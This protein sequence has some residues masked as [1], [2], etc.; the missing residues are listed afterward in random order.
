[1]IIRE[2]K[3]DRARYFLRPEKKLAVKVVDRE[4]FPITYDELESELKKKI[5]DIRKEWLVTDKLCDIKTQ[6]L[7][8]WF[9]ID[10]SWECQRLIDKI[11]KPF[12]SEPDG[13]V[14]KAKQFPI[15]DLIQFRNGFAPC[16]WHND[17]S[18]SMKLY[19]ATNTVYCFG[20]HHSGDPIDVVCA[21]W[22]VEFKE[23]VELLNSK[24]LYNV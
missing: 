4:Y 23:A 24:K 19:K 13:D 22:E 9:Y 18:P 20:C 10:W 1:M 3:L 5:E 16:I 7:N 2:E 17:D 15:Q 11:K 8:K 12:V 14:N 21:L 6:E